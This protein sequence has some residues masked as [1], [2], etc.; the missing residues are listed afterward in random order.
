MLSYSSPFVFDQIQ[1]VCV[2]LMECDFR[3]YLYDRMM[4]N[5]YSNLDISYSSFKRVTYKNHTSDR[6]RPPR[7]LQFLVSVDELPYG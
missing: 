1:C 3:N 4:Y 6:F 5:L 2:L 7:L